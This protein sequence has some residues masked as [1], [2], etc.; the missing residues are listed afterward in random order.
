MCQ[1]TVNGIAGQS[2][3]K[4]ALL[5][6]GDAVQ[7]LYGNLQ[8]VI[9]KARTLLG[10]APPVSVSV[11]WHY[12]LALRER[13]GVRVV[14]MRAKSPSSPRA[15]S[16]SSY[17]FRSKLLMDCRATLATTTEWRN[18]EPRQSSLRA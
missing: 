11:D 15:A 16:V 9:A 1:Q 3:P 12:S 10:W 18:D 13:A 14:F 4:A 7:R 2:I 5:G 17:F 8:V 6:K